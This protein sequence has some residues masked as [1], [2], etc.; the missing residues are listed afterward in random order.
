MDELFDT[1]KV[2]KTASPDE[3]RAAFLNWKKS[4]QEIL[5]HGSREEQNQVSANITR[6]SAVYKIYQKFMSNSESSESPNKI[7]DPPP[8]PVPNSNPDLPT[9]SNQNNPYKVAT[10]VLVAIIICGAIAFV[11]NSKSQKT[12]AISELPNINSKVE[13]VSQP[14]QNSQSIQ[15]S[16][17]TQQSQSESKPVDPNPILTQAKRDATQTLFDFHNNITQ[18]NYRRAYECL[19]PSF[20]NALNYEGWASGFR[21]TVS[22]EVSN[23]QFITAHGNQIVLSY[24]L[25][26][27]DNPG[28]ISHFKGTVVLLNINGSWKIDEIINKIP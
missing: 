1:L 6:I 5:K 14:I 15:T 21:T 3:I 2:S 7:S 23:V 9:N 20:Q 4:Q 22:S 26:A 19:T 8:S 17:S 27:I 10:I 16:Q 12:V 28:G 11:M 13:T 24:D 25:K 18:K